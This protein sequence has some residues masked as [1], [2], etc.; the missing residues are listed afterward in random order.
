L[1]AINAGE[2]FEQLTC[3]GGVCKGQLSA[4][5]V[6]VL[7]ALLE[8]FLLYIHGYYLINIFLLF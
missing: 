7:D 8:L 3:I 4:M 1:S 5:T 6:N 2:A